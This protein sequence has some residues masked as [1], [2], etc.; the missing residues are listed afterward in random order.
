MFLRWYKEGHILESHEDREKKAKK[1]QNQEKKPKLNPP[2]RF[3]P[4]EWPPGA[5]FEPEWTHPL[6]KEQNPPNSGHD[7]H[8]KPLK[9]WK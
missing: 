8:P 7:H 1:K 4:P 3:S 6:D 5:P 9:V 2:N